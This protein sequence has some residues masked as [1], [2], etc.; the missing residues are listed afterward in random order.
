MSDPRSF[1]HLLAPGRIGSL[2]LRNRIIMSP[3]GSNLAEKD[4]HL[5]ERIKR[6][7]EERA[8]GGAG[9]IIV[10]VGAIAFP[11]G[12]CN[13][14]QVAISD[15]VY[16]PGLTDLADRIHRSG[17][18]LAIQL[19]HAGKVATQDIGA[20]RPLWVPSLLP[21]KV[22][23]LFED[24]TPEEVGGVTEYFARPGAKLRFHEMSERDIAALVEMF[25]TAADRAR[26]AGFD[27]VEIHAAH[28]YI[29]S[30]FLSPSTNRR[31]DAYGGPLEN[32]GRLL[33]EVIRAV[34]GRVGVGFPVWCR[35]DAKEFRTERGIS[36]E[37]GRRAAELAEAAGAD[38]IHVSAYADP[39]SGVAFTDAPLV[40]QPCGYVSLAEG[41][42]KRVK[43]PVIAVGRIEPE[44]AEAILTA[45]KADFIAMGRKLLADPELPIK[46][47]EGRRE[48]IRP[49]IYCYTCVGKIFLNQS[50]CCAVN[51]ATGREAEFGIKPAETPRRVL[52]VGGGP[53]GMEAARVAALRGHRVTLCEKSERLGGTLVFSSLVYEAN[54]K[55]AEYLERQVREFG[56]DLRMGQE[57]TSRFVEQHQPDVILVAVGA[58]HRDPAI[59]GEDRPHVLAGGDLRDL[60]TGGDGHGA[61]GKLSLGQRVIVGAGRLL[62]LA[63]HVS[64]IRALTRRWM[65]VGKRV[66]VIGGGLVGV[67]L[68]E[69]LCE[70]GRRVW[71]LEEGNTLAVEMALPRR[72]RVL[73]GLREHGVALLTGVRVEEITDAGV[74]YTAKDGTRSSVPIDT[75]ILASGAGE[76]RGLA[77]ALEGLGAEVH[78]LGDCRGVGYI[79]GAMMDAARIAR[80][81]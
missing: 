16:L 14:N 80:L 24:L 77:D 49:C 25:A 23:D 41:I 2:Q 31:E 38:A 29:L 53:A 74:V 3:M 76:N 43:V 8:R 51:P 70:R 12:A 64:F 19:Q 15:D 17:A 34:K 13:P 79:E 67:E 73:H 4:G 30:S 66:A 62:G 78:L 7:Y 63:D 11:A 40:H 44:E 58:G 42:K 59:P 50:N 55:L 21:P 39:T 54:G 46:L 75:V 71:I 27:A 72:W 6:Y 69:F 36:I 68:A 22:G 56:I 1:R 10:G 65:P 37:D 57:V 81:I 9:L 28:G 45:G 48:D 60:M 5:G 32:R 35:L 20:G 47:G 52:V 33:V 18:K 61:E 26:R